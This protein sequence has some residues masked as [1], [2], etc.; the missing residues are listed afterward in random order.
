MRLRSYAKVNLALSVGP[1]IPA[2]QANAGYHPIASWVHAID[3][4]DEV[5]I[6]SQGVQAGRGL[7]GNASTYARLWS[8][9][10]RCEWPEDSDL[11]VRAHRLIERELSRPVP[12][13]YAIRKRIPAG[14]GL[15]GGS[16]NAACVLDG[17]NH[18]LGGPIRHERLVELSRLL[19]SDVAFFLDTAHLGVDQPPRPAI[20]EELGD[21]I[22]RVP[23]ASGC[24][25]LILP[26]FGCETRAV[27]KE[28]DAS[29]RALREREVREIARRSENGL[30]SWE[31]LNDLFE[32]ACRVQPE[33]ARR[34]DSIER[35]S[36]QR[37]HMSGSGSTL[38]LPMRDAGAASSL[39]ERLHSAI[40]D[41][42][43][44]MRVALV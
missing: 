19:G 4:C 9:G 12:I 14:G 11:G 6:E 15:G 21:R 27:Y 18:L 41:T 23:P 1:A 20:V 40:G 7:S 32:P 22:E 26:T 30:V 3:L 42:A 13:R 39:V 17:L 5:E 34:A 44:V 10:S 28:Y 16:S 24:L 31:P 33:L 38:F 8:N 36:G 29:P 25:V 43:R 37:V 35:A 2:G